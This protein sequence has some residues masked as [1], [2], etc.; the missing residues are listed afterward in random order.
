MYV[1]FKKTVTDYI[2]IESSRNVVFVTN[3]FNQV[4]GTCKLPKSASGLNLLGI[5]CCAKFVIAAKCTLYIHKTSINKSISGL[6]DISL[7]ILI[8]EL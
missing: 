3:I 5:K 2:L 4:P 6:F 7:V 1:G 8:S